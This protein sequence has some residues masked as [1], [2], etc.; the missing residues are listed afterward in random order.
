MDFA[1]LPGMI[2]KHVGMLKAAAGNAL[3]NPALK[4]MT[5]RQG[6]YNSTVDKRAEIYDK[7]TGSERPLLE[8]ILGVAPS[9][10]YAVS[11]QHELFGSTGDDGGEGDTFRHMA[12]SA[13]LQQK[14]PK[15]AQDFGD[16]HEM[17][18]HL[19]GQ[20]PEEESRDYGNNLRGRTI[21]K[22]TNNRQEAETLIRATMPRSTP[23][24][25]S[26][27]PQKLMEQRQAIWGKP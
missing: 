24:V 27:G 26:W 20:S 23:N 16:L 18:G 11:R 25:Q 4:A 1:E 7:A 3:E 6:V 2:T 13:D 12:L 19:G 17:Q 15:H 14:N 10:E 5:E 22:Y 9:S 21:G 8:Q